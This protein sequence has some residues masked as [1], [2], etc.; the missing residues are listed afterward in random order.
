MTDEFDPN[1]T[2][3][4]DAKMMRSYDAGDVVTLVFAEELEM[5][6]NKL[7][8]QLR[9]AVE[10]LQNIGTTS[11]RPK[12]DDTSCFLPTHI[13]AERAVRESDKA[14]QAIERV[15]Q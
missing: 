2:P 12:P 5:E 6:R 15:G 9:I 11:A 10:A 7:K 13:V 4:C 1:A 14:L 3:E 8:E